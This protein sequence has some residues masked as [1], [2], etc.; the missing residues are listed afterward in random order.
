MKKRNIFE[1]VIFPLILLL[2][3]LTGIRQGLDVSDMAYSLSNFQYFASMDGTWIVATFLA[4]AAGWLL[5]RLPFGDTLTGLYFYT[6]LVQSAIAMLAYRRLK[7]RMPAVLVFAGEVTALGLCWCPSAVLYNYLTYLLMTAG[8]LLLYEGILQGVDEKA[9]CAAEAK[10]TVYRYY[11]P[12]GICLGANVAVRMPNVVQAAFI[13]AVWYGA[14]LAGG[15]LRRA[16][17]DTLWCMLGYVIGFCVPFL[18]ICIRY[19]FDAYPAMVRTMFAM[20]EKAVDYKPASMVTGMLGDYKT[21]LYWLVFAG[22]CMAGGLFL[23]GIRRKVAADS[24]KA[25]VLCQILYAAVFALLL[26]FYWGKGVYSFRYYEY[27]S[28]YY[29]AVLLLLV[30]ILTALL[31]L[32]KKE[33][34][35]ACKAAAVLVLVQIAV[36]PLGS[37]ND[38]YPIINNLFVA[39]PFVLWAGY[40]WAVKN[41]KKEVDGT[42]FGI[43]FC[44]LFLFVLVQSIGFHMQFSFQDGVDGT[45]R[46]TMVEIPAKAAGV[47]TTKDNADWLA[48]LAAYTEGAGLT[49]QEAIFY[50]EIPGLG[51]LLDMPP[52]L[53]TFWPDLDSYRMAEFER[54]MARLDVPPVI[55]VAAPIAAYLGEDADGMN[56]FGVDQAA[57][58]ADEKLQDLK[59]YMQAQEYREVFGNGR[60]VVY[61]TEEQQCDK[62]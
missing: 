3:P 24:R 21:G 39:V 9:S 35:A 42:V 26:R 45:K 14:V 48:E 10:N 58:D 36:T 6:A 33:M 52:A 61:V 55:I 47:Y 5:M 29:P 4:N 28:M 38:L 60:Y 40:L 17:R 54:D 57:L 56:W 15:G 32:W 41:K 44:I 27:S 49:E 62:I 46:D 16:V 13:L 7:R 2:Y 25:A 22:I 53:S 50:G 20:T 1:N 31:C 8:I 23:F 19:G 30:T 11:V 37:N 43:P 34:P 12:A 18:T 59:A 51:Y